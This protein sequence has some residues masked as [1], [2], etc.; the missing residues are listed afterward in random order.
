[1]QAWSFSSIRAVS[2]M[3]KE[4]SPSLVLMEILSEE[5]SALRNTPF[6]SVT[7]KMAAHSGSVI[8]LPWTKTADLFN[9]SIK[10]MTFATD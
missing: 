3:L 6:Q 8:C 9:Y 5:S 7:S 4:T 1:M 10:T 2:A